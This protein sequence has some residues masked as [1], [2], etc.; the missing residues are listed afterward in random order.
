LT[1]LVVQHTCKA[2]SVDGSLG[3]KKV[4]YISERTLA[5]CSRKPV[6]FSTYL[7]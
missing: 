3:K 6:S 4:K 5:L 1:A 7:T 2:Q